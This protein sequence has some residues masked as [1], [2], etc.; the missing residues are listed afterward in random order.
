M[1]PANGASTWAR[2]NHIWKGINGVLMA[3]LKKIANHNI[4]WLSKLMSANEIISRS[5]VPTL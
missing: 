3:K 4:F 2:G 1:D 5:E